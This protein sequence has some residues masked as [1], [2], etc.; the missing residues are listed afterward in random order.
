[1]LKPRKLDSFVYHNIGQKIMN[2]QDK[3]FDLNNRNHRLIVNKAIKQMSVEEALRMFLEWNGI[4]GWTSTIL[5]AVRSLDN[6]EVT[7][8]KE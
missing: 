6:A 7:A 3:F 4:C 2:D 1:M 8:E 5:N